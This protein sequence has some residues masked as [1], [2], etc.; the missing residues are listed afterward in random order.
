METIRFKIDEKSLYFGVKNDYVRGETPTVATPLNQS[1]NPSKWHKDVFDFI[2]KDPGLTKL[3]AML[4]KRCTPKTTSKAKSNIVHFYEFKKLLVDGVPLHAN[5][6][7]GMYVKEETDSL[8]LSRTGQMVTNTHKGRLKLH[9]PM[10]LLFKADGFNIDN[11]RVLNAILDLNG[12]FAFIVRGFEV[13]LDD[14]SLN[15]LT[16]LI[17]V[18]GIFTSSVFKIGKGTGKKLLVSGFDS[19]ANDISGDSGFAVDP[20]FQAS[21]GNIH[22]SDLDKA[23][24]E[25]GKLGEE[26]VLSNIYKLID[27]S[28][29][30]VY[31]TSKDYPTSPYDIE[32]T[33]NGVKKYLEVKATSGTKGIFN[34][35]SGEIK[36]MKHYKDNYLLILVTE[37]REK[38][39]KTKSFICDKILKL[40]K[41]YPSIRFIVN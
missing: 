25:N 9:Y 15:F 27:K 19:S 31:H 4:V 12:G 40:K 21:D 20:N 5:A 8:I 41:E 17:G 3:P 23:K 36:F 6:S 16:S 39:P 11:N 18:A 34:M 13:N 26:Y 29:K 32:Y 14:M 22:F 30:D 2:A 35:S 10:G 24:A 33:L 37:V 38:F 7:F 28:V 1:R